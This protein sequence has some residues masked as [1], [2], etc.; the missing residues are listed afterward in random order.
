MGMLAAVGRVR[1]E[2]DRGGAVNKTV[3]G[4]GGDEASNTHVGAL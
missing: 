1:S 2:T 4:L 3:V